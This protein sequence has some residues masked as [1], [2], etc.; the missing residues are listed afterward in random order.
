M[1]CSLGATSQKN[2]NIHLHSTHTGCDLHGGRDRAGGDLTG[3]CS[4][5]NEWIYEETL[6]NLKK[7]VWSFAKQTY[8]L[9]GMSICLLIFYILCSVLPNNWRAITTVFVK[10]SSCFSVTPRSHA[11][12]GMNDL[13][14]LEIGELGDNVL[15]ISVRS[16]A[17]KRIPRCCVMRSKWR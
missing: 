6:G 14:N 4:N 1:V 15:A 13:R 17:K 11:Q 10:L 7:T 9:E 16:A 3:F 5:W 12:E 8:W 2:K